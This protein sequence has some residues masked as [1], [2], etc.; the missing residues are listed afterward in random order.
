MAGRAGEGVVVVVPAFA[1]AED[2]EDEVVGRVVVA[3]ERAAAPD[4]ADRVDAPGDVVHHE[5]TDQA[6]PEEAHERA[7]ERHGD[8]AADDGRDDETEDGPEREQAAHLDDVAVAGHI[9]GIAV[10]VW[11]FAGQHPANV[12]VPEA[13][14]HAPDPLAVV[15][16]RV[17]VVLGI[18][19][20]VVAAVRGDP[21]EDR[22]LARHRARDA[23]DPLHPA[24]ALERL[25]GEVAVEA[26][27][28]AFACD[29]IEPEQE[30][31][32]RPADG[33]AHGPDHRQPGNDRDKR[34][35]NRDRGCDTDSTAGLVG[36]CVIRGRGG[37]SGL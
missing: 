22:A 5:D 16:R 19:M 31:K 30:P 18:G 37:G 9:G 15:V 10:D 8:Q 33:I 13:L 35:K 36:R 7:E 34:K 11:V 25:V 17:R 1:E 28:N 3:L 32:R 14:D 20:L 12:G 24:G 2:A 26:D 6:A 29:E 27:G 23:H 21:I 4:V